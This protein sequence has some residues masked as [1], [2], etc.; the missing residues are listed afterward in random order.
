MERRV[1]GESFCVVFFFGAKRNGINLWSMDWRRI[2]AAHPSEA[3]CETWSA[4]PMRSPL[5]CFGNEQCEGT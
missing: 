4:V 5:Q 2:L 3:D 1:V